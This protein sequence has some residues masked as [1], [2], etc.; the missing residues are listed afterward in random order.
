MT[1]KS[2]TTDDLPALALHDIEY[3]ADD[4]VKNDDSSGTNEGTIEMFHLRSQVTK[5]KVLIRGHAPRK[6]TGKFRKL[7]KARKKFKGAGIKR[8]NAIPFL[9]IKPWTRVANVFCQRAGKMFFIIFF[10]YLS[11][12]LILK[13]FRSALISSNLIL[14]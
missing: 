6:I 3:Q 9:K 8:N 13:S 2:V 4:I 1:L 12:S 11:A 10:D 5:R 14:R 7:I